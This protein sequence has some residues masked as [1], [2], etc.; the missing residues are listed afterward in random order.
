MFEQAAGELR[1][2]LLG[3]GLTA[4]LVQER[5][6]GLVQ[7]ASDASHDTTDDAQKTAEYQRD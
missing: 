2:K 4:V 7:S 1:A 3:T 5:R 6:Q